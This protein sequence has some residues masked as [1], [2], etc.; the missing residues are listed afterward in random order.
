[1]PKY[2][3]T[4]RVRFYLQHGCIFGCK[5]R[6]KI[7]GIMLATIYDLPSISTVLSNAR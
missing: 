1:M 3:R 5:R 7:F 4:K 6:R 2:Y